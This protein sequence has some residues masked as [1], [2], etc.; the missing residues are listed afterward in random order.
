MVRDAELQK[1]AFIGSYMPRRCG[2]ATFTEDVWRAVSE[3]VAGECVVLSVTDPGHHY[4]YPP[5]VRFEIDEQDLASYRRAAD[6]LN[7]SNT[8]VVCVQHEFGIYGG[9][10]GSHLLLLLRALRMPVV[11]TLHT[12]LAEPNPDQRRVMDELV[13]L[14]S[15]LVVMRAREGEGALAPGVP[16]AGGEGRDDPAR[17]PR[18]AVRRSGLLQGPV[19]RRRKNVLLTFGLLS[20][21]KGVENVIRALPQIVKEFPNLVYIVLG[22]THPNLVRGRARRTA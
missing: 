20:P 7:F 2:I 3:Q 16:R 22:A 12:V 5:E 1:I 4:E 11:T 19:R 8:D 21:N 10:A 9:A 14:S 17:H 18:H 6:F 15:R 13:G